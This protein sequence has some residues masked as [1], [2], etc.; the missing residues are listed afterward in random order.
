[1]H[2]DVSCAYCHAKPQELVLEKLPAE[3]CSGKEEGKIGLLKKSMH[4]TSDAASNWERDW[5]GH[6][7]NWGFELG[8]S[9]RNL[10]HNK[11]KESLRFWHTETTL[12]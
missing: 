12:W 7:E 11:K 1:M 6:L 3:A 2:I 5:Q 10:F 9:S 4:G 8:H